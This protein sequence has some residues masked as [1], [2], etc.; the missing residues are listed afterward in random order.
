MSKDNSFGKK[1]IHR[2]EL[3]DNGPG[4][5]DMRAYVCK[6]CGVGPVTV[7][8]LDGKFSINKTAKQQGISSDCN[9]ETVKGVMES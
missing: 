8:V 6:R 1:A 5:D 7:R 9:F 2:W 4:F 3:A